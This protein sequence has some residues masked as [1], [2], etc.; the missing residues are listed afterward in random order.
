MGGGGG[1]GVGARKHLFPVFYALSQI[2]FCVNQK[3]KNP[4]WL[5]V[6]SSKQYCANC[7]PLGILINIYS[8]ADNRYIKYAV[9]HIVA[10]SLIL[11]SISA[12][13][14]SPVFA[15][16]QRLVIKPSLILASQDFPVW[17]QGTLFSETELD[18][19]C[20]LSLI[21]SFTPLKRPFWGW[22]SIKFYM[23]MLHLQVQ[24]LTLQYTN[25]YQHGTPFIYLQQNC[26]PFLYLK[27]KLK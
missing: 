23:G 20:S 4:R 27:D 13:L 15:P 8:E 17:G 6:P 14:S 12:A 21:I 5:T 26:T 19:L 7:C 9:Y 24:T 1:G 2:T 18:L 10:T 25:F 16:E 22:Y 11:G 3:L